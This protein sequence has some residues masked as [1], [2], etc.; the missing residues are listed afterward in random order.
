MPV[1]IAGPAGQDPTSG[2]A[3]TLNSGITQNIGRIATDNFSVLN[4]TQGLALEGALQMGAQGAARAI[5]GNI[6]LR[7]GANPAYVSFGGRATSL[8]LGP[9]LQ[10]PGQGA[11]GLNVL[12]LGQGG[13][14]TLTIQDGAIAALDLR[15]RSD[16]VVHHPVLL[17]AR[18]LIDAGGTLRFMQS[19]SSVSNTNVT[20]GV[21][22][23]HMTRNAMEGRGTSAKES[24]IDIYLPQDNDV[25]TSSPLGGVDF[26][27]GTALVVNGT[28]LGG[29]RVNGLTR[30]AA[31]MGGP[32]P[33]SNADKVANLLSTGRLQ[34]LTGSGGFLTPAAQGATVP[35][36][37]EWAASVPVGLRV[38]NSNAGGDDV[39][40]AGVGMW[41]HNLH[42]D[43]GAAVAAPNVAFNHGFVTGNGTLAA[44]PETPVT[45]G[46]TN[47]TWIAPGLPPGEGDVVGTLSVAGDAVLNLATNVRININSGG[48]DLLEVGGAVTLNQPFLNVILDMPTDPA[49]GTQFGILA[50]DGTDGYGGSGRFRTLP[51]GALVGANNAGT[52]NPVAFRITY[53]GNIDGGG[54]DVVLTAIPEP[55]VLTGVGVA[56]AALLGRR[57]RKPTAR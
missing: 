2:P 52:G 31:L 46:S 49:E 28:G 55:S 38:T 25:A 51:E 40:L 26:Q 20:G 15:H 27:A 11:A 9:V 14:D 50:N 34:G 37:G 23:F 3:G 7:G 44:A 39:S 35:I 48:N 17:D 12:Y 57:R 56:G 4:Y 36:T 13:N 43:A 6:V 22:G 10:P 8:I 30:P 5:D 29:L 41:G 47:E 32:D 18:T 19:L 42:V 16:Q 1:T 54:N 45:F 21:V 33:V 53:R 24:V